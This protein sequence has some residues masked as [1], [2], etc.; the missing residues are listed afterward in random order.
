[1]L[2][3]FCFIDY[4]FYPLIFEYCTGLFLYLPLTPVYHVN[5]K[6]GNVLFYVLKTN[7]NRE[8]YTLAV[9]QT[10]HIFSDSD[11]DYLPYLELESTSGVSLTYLPPILDGTSTS[12]SIPA[13][14][15]IGSTNHTSV[16]VSLNVMTTTL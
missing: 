3:L 5:L 6:I 1:M 2:E 12:I 15:I 11:G 10:K 4:A 14:F 13:G 16:Y 9:T 7:I 8:N